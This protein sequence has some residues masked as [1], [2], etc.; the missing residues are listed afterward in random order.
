MIGHS[1][2]LED[3][4]LSIAVVKNGRK[5]VCGSQD[6][7]LCIFSW[8]QWG[9]MSNRFPGHPQS[10]ETLV[11]IDEDTVCTGSS[12]GIIRI[13][14]LHPNKLLGLVGDHEDFPVEMMKLSQDK[15]L[16]GSVSHSN[17]IHFWDVGYLHEEEEDE[18][19]DEEEKGQAEVEDSDDDSDDGMAIDHGHTGRKAFPTARE[20]FFADL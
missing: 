7:V 20:Q 13:V 3:E 17:K 6:G 4:L 9:D 5:V 15:K 11:K 1:D 8:G 19:E 2:E 16:I 12:D 10:V 14:Q 18:E